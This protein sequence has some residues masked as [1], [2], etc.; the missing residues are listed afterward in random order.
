MSIRAASVP[1]HSKNVLLLLLLLMM[2][3]MTRLTVGFTASFTASYA[4]TARRRHSDA[5]ILLTSSRLSLLHETKHK[6]KEQK[7]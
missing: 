2:M 5:T 4:V 3:M 1:A 6:N 7:N